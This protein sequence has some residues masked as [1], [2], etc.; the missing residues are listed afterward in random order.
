MTTIPSVAEYWTEEQRLRDLVDNL[1]TTGNRADIYL[2]M[3]GAVRRQ[4][5]H[6]PAIYRPWERRGA[7]R[8]AR[9][10]TALYWALAHLE[11]GHVRDAARVA[12]IPEDP[13]HTD[14]VTSALAG[15]AGGIT[16]IGLAELAAALGPDWHA[17]DAL[18]NPHALAGAY[19]GS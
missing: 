1:A 5:H 14:A 11:Q 18:T 2:S 8:Q 9:R 15:M 6:I 13:A 17:A 12:L 19:G 3:A 7:R 10:E 16:R 4:A